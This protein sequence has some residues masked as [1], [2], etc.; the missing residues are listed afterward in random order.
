MR[1]KHVKKSAKT[2]WLAVAVICSISACVSDDYAKTPLDYVPQTLSDGWEISTPE[3]EGLDPEVIR[4]IYQRVFSEDKYKPAMSLLIVRHGKLVAEGYMRD[5]SD[6]DNVNNVK[7]VTKSV[8]SLSL[9]IAIDKGVFENINVP[10]Y[11]IIPE[12]FPDNDTLKRQIT[13]RNLVMMQSGLDYDEDVHDWRFGVENPSDS[14]R[15]HLSMPMRWTPGQRFNYA[16][17][18]PHLISGAI[19]AKTGKPL[20]EFAKEN[21]FSPLGITNYIWERTRDGVSIGGYALHLIPRDM[22]K[23][24]QLALN[25]GAWKSQQIVSQAWIAES[26]TTYTTNIGSGPYGYYWWISPDRNAYYASGAG[27]QYIYV[28]PNLEIVIVFT[29]WPY[30]VFKDFEFAD[31]EDEVFRIVNSVVN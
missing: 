22:A 11:D 17:S 26:T 18:D 25:K 2:L 10:L 12:S 29:A 23:L 15:W 4:G 27:G 14:L 19:K 8:V 30:T 31:F 9:G 1:T 28:I 5:K 16:N 21:L 20:D 13:L 7:S 24:G 6:R 3:A